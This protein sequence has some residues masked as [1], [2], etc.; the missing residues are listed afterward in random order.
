MIIIAAKDNR[1]S[2][3]VSKNILLTRLCQRDVNNMLANPC[4]SLQNAL[5]K[6]PL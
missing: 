2:A 3:R 6:T 4:E 5:N 1:S